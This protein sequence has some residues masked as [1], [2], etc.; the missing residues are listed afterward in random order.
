MDSNEYNNIS[1]K[2]R[3]FLY[4]ISNYIMNNNISTQYV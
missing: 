4:M 3:A 2:I 1:N